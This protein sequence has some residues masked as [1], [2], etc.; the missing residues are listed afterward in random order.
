MNLKSNKWFKKIILSIIIITLLT[1]VF[2]VNLKNYYKNN[3]Y[4]RNNNDKLWLIKV[5]NKIIEVN[6]IQK[7]FEYNILLLEKK[8]MNNTYDMLKNKIYIKNLYKNILSNLINKYLIKDYIEKNDIKNDQKNTKN[9]IMKIDLFKK[10]NKFDSNLYHQFLNKI[11]F[12]ENEYLEVIGNKI[13][14]KF[15]FNDIINSENLFKKDKIFLKN[16]NQERILCK[17]YIIN[18]KKNISKQT[19][20]EQEINNFYNT[21]KKFF[22]YQKKFRIKFLKIIPFLKPNQKIKKSD[23]LK[24]FQN[25]IKKYSIIQNKEIS[26]INFNNK[27]KAILELKKIKNHKNKTFNLKKIFLNNNNCIKNLHLSWIKNTELLKIINKINLKKINQISQI[28]KFKNQFIIFRLDDIKKYKNKNIDQIKHNI[29]KNLKNQ[30]KKENYKKLIQKINSMS[31]N[32][33]QYFNLLTKNIDKKPIITD[34]FTI[35]SI[36]KDINLKNIKFFFKNIKFTKKNKNKILNYR[37]FDK[38]KNIF[39]QIL[40]YQNNT[41]KPLYKIKKKIIDLIKIK[42]SK[43]QAFKKIEKLEKDLNQKSYKNLNLKNILFD[44]KKFLIKNKNR[45][46]LM[47]IK[48]FNKKY[49]YK[50]PIYI[51]VTNYNNKWVILKLYKKYYIKLKK[52]EINRIYTKYKI[53]NQKLLITLILESLRSKAK[54]QYNINKY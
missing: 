21:Y 36:P 17:K 29:K 6:Q 10:N 1:S 49:M 28:I 35:N 25:N 45:N 22:T 15:F 52:N 34:W 32:N 23:I 7:I 38:N 39:I 53:K 14:E 24:E 42:K 12:N 3:F 5:N 4:T 48:K 30:I 44:K 26:F 27:K 11:N 18:F 40:D 20:T 2:M 54:I 50:K 8:S 13:N 47:L 9:L 37:F 51:K 33:T 46:S 41:I 31:I 19:Y 16:L 43:I